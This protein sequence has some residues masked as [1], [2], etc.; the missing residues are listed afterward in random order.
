MILV[1]VGCGPPPRIHPPPPRIHPPH[2]EDPRV[3][4]FPTIHSVGPVVGEVGKSFGE[5][6]DE[7]LRAVVKSTACD[8]L[9]E[10]VT[11]HQFPSEDDVTFSLSAG[12]LLEGISQVPQAVLSQMATVF[13]GTLARALEN[14]QGVITDDSANRAATAIGC[15]FATAG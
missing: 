6:T 8:A 10:I 1:A 9:T 3:P 5:A 13:R 7:E 12:F 4:E 2:I 14:D 15:H 11:K